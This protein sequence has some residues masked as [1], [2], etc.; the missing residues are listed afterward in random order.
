MSLP[1]SNVT[2]TMSFFIIHGFYDSSNQPSIVPNCNL[3]SKKPLNVKFRYAGGDVTIATE[4][5]LQDG[6][7]YIDETRKVKEAWQ[8]KLKEIICAMTGPEIK[9]ISFVP[10]NLKIEQTYLIEKIAAKDSP[11]TYRG[12]IKPYPTCVDP[13]AHSVK[14]YVER[15]RC[16]GSELGV[17]YELE[18]LTE[19]QAKDAKPV[20]NAFLSDTQTEILSLTFMDETVRVW[21]HAIK[22]LS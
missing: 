7:R 8:A 22:N 6:A 14:D 17:D 11:A 20:L 15:P 2:S 12:Y 19:K 10:A 4:R 9:A 18:S 16:I 1:S 13:N 5:L 3:E 21:T